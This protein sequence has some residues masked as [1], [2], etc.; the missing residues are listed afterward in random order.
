PPGATRL[1][2]PREGDAVLRWLTPDRVDGA[3]WT[4]ARDAFPL[5]ETRDGAVGRLWVSIET[6]GPGWAHLPSG[7]KEVALQRILVSREQPGAGFVPDQLV[8][9]WVSPLEGVVAEISG[10]ASADGLTRT[11][12]SDAWVLDSVVDGASTMKLYAD[13]LWRG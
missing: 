2:D 5:E 11:S 7:P 4:G 12:V 3:L 9:R 8:H 10:P 6:L 1:T 13:Q